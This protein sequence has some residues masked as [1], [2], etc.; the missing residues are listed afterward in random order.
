MPP[1]V[2]WAAPA[3]DPRNPWFSWEFIRQ[4]IDGLTAALEQ[5][6]SLTV[7][8]VLVAAAISIPL[9]VLSNKVTRLTGPILAFSGILYTIPSLA[10][11]AFLGPTFGLTRTTVLIGL[12]M[13]ALLIIVRN[14]LT[15]LRQVPAEVLDAARGMGYG[16]V[17]QLWRIEL[18]L[19]LPS[20]LT[21]LR[22]AT[23]S[24]VALVT[25]GTIVGFGGFGNVILTGF[26]SN[27]YKPQIMAGTLGCLGLA[28]IFDLLLIGAGRLMRRRSWAAA[29]AYGT[30][31]ATT[32]LAAAIAVGGAR[33][34]AAHVNIWEQTL[35]W[36][37]DPLNWTN[38]D[39]ILA[40]TREHLEISAAAVA[41][42]CLVAWPVGIWL[43]HVGRGGAFV[44]SVAN[45]AR[46]MPTVALL[47][48]FPLTF[49]GFGYLPI[50]LALAIFAVPPLLANAYLGLR[51]VDPDVREAAQGMGLSGRQVV[52][53]VELPL[54]VPYL[55]G[56]FRTAAVQVVATATLAAFVNGGGLGMIIS[57]GFGL[58]IASGAGQIVTGGLVVVVLCLL[59][60]GLL[61]IVERAVTPRHMRRP[62]RA[63]RSAADATLPDFARV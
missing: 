3:D 27:F 59:L 52:A 42:A 36:L 21:G 16:P 34:G 46:A 41:L 7:T 5:H 31:A 61:T 37:N 40:R 15:G 48:I 18:P 25:V 12:V 38:P 63:A 23:V 22:I 26:N 58:G 8:T 29:V 55:A 9:A 51:E 35:A 47:T 50:I 43:G 53:R 17:K 30:A 20:I 10:L 44:V 2:G 14:T 45:L 57:R 24:T 60:E 32:L 1:L 33:P 49:I 11:F 19:A 13:Y 56:G 39:G 6:V 62:G 54:A 28:L 4:N